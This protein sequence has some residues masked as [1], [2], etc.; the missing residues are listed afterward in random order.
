MDELIRSIKKHEGLRLKPY[1][2]TNGLATIGWGRCL[3]KVGI[4]HAE[5]EL[6]LKADIARAVENFYLLPI[7]VIQNCNANR[8]RVL[9]EMLFNLGFNGVLG[10]VKMLSAIEVGDFERAADEMIDSQW[11]EEV[12]IRGRLMAQTMREG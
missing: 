9:C 6:L 4:S 2:D 3:D 10:F 12:G 11:A 5:A 8:R 7:Q 1:T